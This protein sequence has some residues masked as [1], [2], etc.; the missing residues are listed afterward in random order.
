MVPS[1]LSLLLEIFLVRKTGFADEIIV[2]EYQGQKLS[3][4]TKYN[5]DLLVTPTIR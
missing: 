4:I 5:I 1:L 3:D 2:E